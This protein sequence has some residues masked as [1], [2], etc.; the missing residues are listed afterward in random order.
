MNIMPSDAPEFDVQVNVRLRCGCGGY[1]YVKIGHEGDA[2]LVPYIICKEHAF[3]DSFAAAQG[4][5]IDEVM[6]RWSGMA[7][8]N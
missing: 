1:V 7:R 3:S 5:V 4:Y 8:L 6:K 2:S